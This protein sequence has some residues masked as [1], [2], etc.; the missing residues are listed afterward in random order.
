MEVQESPLVSLI[1]IDYNSPQYT[2]ALVESLKSSTYS[3]WELIIVDNAQNDEAARLLSDLGS[4]IRFYTAPQNLG[5][6]GGNNYG[7]EQAKGDYFFFINNDTEVTPE[8]IGQLVSRMQSNERIGLISPKIKFFETNLIQYAGYTELSKTMRNEAVGSKQEDN[9]QYQSLIRTP[10]AH[11]AA[12]MTS[13]TVVEQIGMMPELYF[14]YYEEMD[15][16]E[17]IKRAGLEIW[18]DQSAVIYHKESMSIGKLNPLKTYYLSRN[19]ILFSRRNN[20]LLRNIFFVLYSYF[21]VLPL[22]SITF[23]LKREWD[24]LNSL[25]KAHLWHLSNLQIRE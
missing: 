19:R 17:I 1:T 25:V 9:D 11:G 15:W 3:N 2:L 14:L 7:V 10:F 4:N 5:F 18:V 6:A 21:I 8:L 13:R 16:S 22:K 24:H 20:P 23:C 12:M